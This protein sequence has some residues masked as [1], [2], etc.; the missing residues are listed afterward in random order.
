MKVTDKANELNVENLIVFYTPFEEKSF[1]YAQIDGMYWEDMNIKSQRV[2]H[3]RYSDK[4]NIGYELNLFEVNDK[5]T[6]FA[7]VFTNI[8]I[9]DRVFDDVQTFIPSLKRFCDSEGLMDFIN[10]NYTE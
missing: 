6:V 7:T 8:I 4:V 2:Y 1:Y 10:K 5:P 9:K 3:E